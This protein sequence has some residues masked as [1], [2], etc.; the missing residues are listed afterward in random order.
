MS[1]TNSAVVTLVGA[2]DSG[3]LLEGRNVER[4]D[5]S[6]TLNLGADA[7]DVGT[8]NANALSAATL[9]VNGAYAAK[10]VQT[11]NG[12]VAE[13]ASLSMGTLILKDNSSSGKMKV[14]GTLELSGSTALYDVIGGELTSTGLLTT[15]AAA[16]AQYADEA[17]AVF[18]V[19]RQVTL[20]GAA[21]TV[22]SA[23]GLGKAVSMKPVTPS[24]PS[25]APRPP[26]SP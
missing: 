26:R 14:E 23:A 19:D 13:G 24:I 8:V 18:Y 2:K 5:F 21:V 9:N 3:N 7:E 17:D 22:G 20:S 16:A 6:G 4:L 10:T 12:T 1:V 15:N 11:M 25:A